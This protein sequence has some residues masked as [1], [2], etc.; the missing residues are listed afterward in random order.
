MRRRVVFGGS[1]CFE[2][3]GCDEDAR[4]FGRGNV[5]MTKALWHGWV[6]VLEGR[7]MG[8]AL[9]GR[10]DG[11]LGRE[12]K[13]DYNRYD[14]HCDRMRLYNFVGRAE[15]EVA[16][17]SRWTC[18]PRSI[19]LWHD[20]L[21]VIP[22]VEKYQPSTTYQNV[23]PTKHSQCRSNASP[24]NAQTRHPQ[25]HSKR[26]EAPLSITTTSTP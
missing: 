7:G 25:D 21:S 16:T 4:S 26:L 2:D 13:R 10:R 6:S 11:E 12:R 19:C 17:P 8:G 14:G 20:P 5:S 15:R 3:L 23:I 9:K 22:P 18:P 24:E 1:L